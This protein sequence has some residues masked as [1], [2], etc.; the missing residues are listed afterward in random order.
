MGERALN[1]PSYAKRGHLRLGNGQG[2]GTS[3]KESKGGGDRLKEEGTGKRTGSY[4]QV[5]A[6]GQ[7]ISSRHRLSA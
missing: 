1:N 7:S 2:V 4:E 5:T 3:Q 6:K